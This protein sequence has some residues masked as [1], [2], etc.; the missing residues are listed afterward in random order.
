[1][2]LYRDTYQH[3]FSWV[4]PEA[5]STAFPR[6]RFDQEIEQFCADLRQEQGVLLLPGTCYD[7]G[8]KHFRIGFG[9]KNMPE[10]L[11][12]LEAYIQRL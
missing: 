8:Q 9:R 10:Y 12:R 11:E 7:F 2:L 6:I 5:S 4:R 1:M 3:L